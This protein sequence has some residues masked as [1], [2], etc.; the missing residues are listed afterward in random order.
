MRVSQT[1]LATLKESPTDAE[2]VSHKLMLRAGLIRR[3]ASGLYTWLPLG[4]RILH[5]IETIV[6]QEMERAGALELLMPAVQPAE[7]WRESGRWDA[8]GPELQRLKDRHA[9]EF[10]LGPTHEEVVTD[11]ARRE[12]R[13]YKQLPVNLYQIQTKFRDEIRPRFGVMRSREFIMKDAYSFDI[14][15]NGQRR[16][17]DRMRDAYVRIFDR[18]G[19]NYRIVDADSGSIGGSRSNEFHVLADSG[20]DAIG[21]AGGATGFAANVE[22]IACPPGGAPRPDPG[23][24]LAPVETPAQH[25]IAELAD[26]LAIGADRCLKT[27]LVEGANGDLVALA[28]RGD[29]ELNAIKTAGLAQVKAPLAFASRERV[30]EVCG[31]EPG[32]LGPIG[33]D[34]P[35]IADHAAA[36]MAD[37][38]CG[39]NREGR[40]LTG[41]NWGRDLPEPMVA[42]LRNAVDGDPSPDGSGPLTVARG[43]EVGHIFQLG[44]K[45]S[46]AMNAVVLD[47][48]GRAATLHMGCYGIGITR[49]AAAAIEQ[50][51]DDR[52]IIWPTAIAPYQLVL[53]PM[54]MHKS[55][56]L[57]DAIDQLYEALCAAGVEVLLDDRA[58][59]PG[60][61]YA[62]A[63]LLGIP[64][65][66]VLGE[67]GLDAGKVEYKR[68]RDGDSGELALGDAAESIRARI[69]EDLALSA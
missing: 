23:A 65:R 38:V 21:F 27:L 4:V 10:C 17:Y 46:E 58:V 3:L 7:L 12:I 9:R 30:L 29:H 39:A 33:L 40:H 20:E 66:L 41:V 1:F 67:R 68:R 42:D 2:I 6:R 37:F 47:E 15:E 56:R 36:A 16:S 54:N 31:C 11:L 24:A 53:L 5:K 43:I 25:T 50:G 61:M 62:D 55:R 63:E 59:R 14:D 34:I 51:H 8:Y 48:Q 57:R 69:A 60:V 22:L 13:S 49:I 45:Y 35:V 44:T 28:L 18:L 64:H 52:G 19:L 26:F 32:S